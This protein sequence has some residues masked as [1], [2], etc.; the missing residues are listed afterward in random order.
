MLLGRGQWLGSLGSDRK[1]SLGVAAWQKS[2]ENYW[3]SCYL[4]IVLIR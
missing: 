4:H 3:L 1:R 2:H